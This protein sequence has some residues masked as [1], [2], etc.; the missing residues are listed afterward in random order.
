M[1]TTLIRGVRVALG[2]LAVTLALA[3]A[4]SGGQAAGMTYLDNGRIRVGVDLDDGGKITFL[5][6]SSGARS[7]TNLV[8]ESEQSYYRPELGQSPPWGANADYATVLTSSNDGRT[9][10]IKAV[11]L[12][13]TSRP[14]CECT[15]EQWV[16]I[17]GSAVHVRNR[18]SNFLSDATRYPAWFQE[19]PAL[20]TRGGAYRLITYDRGAPYTH[21]PLREGKHSDGGE[22]FRTP[23]PAFFATEHW[24]ALVGDDDFGVGLFEPERVLF[25]GVTGV[26]GLGDWAANG[27]LTAPTQEILDANATYEYRYTLIAG[28]VDAIR[29]YAYSHRPDSRP[30]YH[31]R[32]DRQSWYFRSAI[33]R[34]FPIRGALRISVEQ[35]DPQAIGPESWWRAKQVPRIYVRGR[36]R[37]RQDIAEVFWRIPRLGESGNRARSFTVVN[38]GLF[39]TYR[40]DLF[41]SPTYRAVVTG[42]RLDPVNSAEPGG[43]V[44]ITCISWKPCPVDR[45]SEARLLGNDG[46]PF[47]DDF[48]N[49]LDGDTWWV[50][51]SGT[52]PTVSV[53]DDQL[54][55][56]MPAGSKPDPGQTWISANLQ[57]RCRIKGDFDMQVDFRLLEWPPT[58]GVHVDFVVADERA[59]V[60]L[61]TGREEIVA[62]F[63]PWVSSIADDGMTGSYRVRRRGS[64]V[65]GYA[66]TQGGWY[67]V[68]RGRF[69][70]PDA[71]ARLQVG[72]DST[73][74]ARQ[75]VL[76]AF[77]NFRISSGRLVC[78]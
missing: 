51:R 29:A 55:L 74:F 20:Y 48:S 49:G 6:P 12:S 33:D 60:R 61:N 77:D 16:T 63:P 31:F 34:G 70:E 78:P 10:Y 62:W 15:I 75:P 11:P 32:T 37:T 28:T 69:F 18:L 52:G 64:W 8:F 71:Y 57:T 76:V 44:D 68:A 1:N 9:I 5:A 24:A 7:G 22:L 66:L 25:A 73:E 65:F 67:E 38:D 42:L 3:P 50:G 46:V 53:A 40:V 39:H 4:G 58:N 47:L 27:Y 35:E 17:E 14:T 43:L 56:G 30:D 23:G 13:I 2:A 41:P 54:E 26:P 45:K 19:L 59:M 21:G 72:V 36:W